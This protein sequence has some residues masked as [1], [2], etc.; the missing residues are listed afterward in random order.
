MLEVWCI[1]GLLY[2]AVPQNFAN[3]ASESFSVRGICN[4][5]DIVLSSEL[6]QLIR[7]LFYAIATTKSLFQPNHLI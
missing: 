4:N 2:E 7:V 5:S 6:G 1:L 3:I